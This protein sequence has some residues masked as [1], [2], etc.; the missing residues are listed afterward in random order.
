METNIKTYIKQRGYTFS[1]VATLLG[2]STVTLN[3]FITRHP[4]TIYY[5]VQGLPE[6]SH[7]KRERLARIRP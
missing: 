3:K 6:M 7:I 5:A 1:A 4:K 2:F